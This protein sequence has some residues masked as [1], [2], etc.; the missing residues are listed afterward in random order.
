[1][2]QQVPDPALF[3]MYYR[4]WG[5]EDLKDQE[6]VSSWRC[7]VVVGVFNKL[8]LNYI[9]MYV[10]VQGSLLMSTYAAILPSMD[11]QRSLTGPF[12]YLKVSAV[13]VKL[14]LGVR[15]LGLICSVAVLGKLYPLPIYAVKFS[16]CRLLQACNSFFIWINVSILAIDCP[17]IYHTL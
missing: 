8:L 16:D 2:F 5:M 3:K 7:P 17:C 6:Q 1:M 14:W 11:W 10:C 12:W 15:G 4:A 9:K 13:T